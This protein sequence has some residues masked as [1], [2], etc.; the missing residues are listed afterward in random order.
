MKKKISKKSL[1][2]TSYFSPCGKKSCKG[3]LVKGTMKVDG[4]DTKIVV[5]TSSVK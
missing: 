3:F 4:M 2:N 1:S 5:C